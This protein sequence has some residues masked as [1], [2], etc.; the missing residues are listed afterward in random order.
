MFRSRPVSPI[1]PRSPAPGSR[2]SSLNFELS[3]LSSIS[4][5]PFLAAL[6][7]LPQLNENKPTL[8][9]VFAI[10][11]SHVEFNFFVC[12][13][14]KKHPGRVSAFLNFF[15]AQAEFIPV[16][17]GI[18]ANSRQSPSERSEVKD[19]LELKN[20]AVPPVTRHK[21]AVAATA[22]SLP[23]VSNHQSPVT[24][25][26][27]IRTYEKSASNPF[28]IRT[29]K[30]QDLK[31][32]RMN[33]YEKTGEGASGTANPGCPLTVLPAKEHRVHDTEHGSRT[34]SHK[35]RVTEQGALT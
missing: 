4:L 17:P 16:N 15:V 3:T 1:L 19:P 27:R 21:S 9:L 29:S 11:T 20:L 6:T 10:L 23:Q 8:S 24:K 30:T 28:R 14:Y 7:V 18:C 26:C 22:L 34:T 2:P 35:S 12:H 32:F 13:S 5:T 31:P 33:T 25:S